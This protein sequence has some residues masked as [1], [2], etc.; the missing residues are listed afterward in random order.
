MKLKS[1]L[2]EVKMAYEPKKKGSGMSPDVVEQT[3]MQ[4]QSLKRK[5]SQIFNEFQDLVQENRHNLLRLQEMMG[6]KRTY[7]DDYIE[8][9]LREYYREKFDA[10]A[11]A[12]ARQKAP[13][14]QAGKEEI[15]TKNKSKKF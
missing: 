4:I 15:L 12:K 3:K 10:D 8:R 7:Y 5:Q 6:M 1:Q 9:K 2:R 13:D 11:L 14:L